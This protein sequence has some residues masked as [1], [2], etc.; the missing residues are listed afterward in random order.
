[1]FRLYW[2]P[3][4]RFTLYRASVPLI[5]ACGAVST[6][7]ST[8]D[9]DECTGQTVIVLHK[10]ARKAPIVIGV[11]SD[12]LPAYLRHGDRLWTVLDEIN[13]PCIPPKSKP[14]PGADHPVTIEDRDMDGSYAV[15]D[16]NSGD[17]MLFLRSTA[18][19]RLPLPLWLG[20]WFSGRL[21]PDD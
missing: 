1:L 21:R 11:S 14:K 9:D 7:A 20:T 13:E 3:P 12:A 16:G 2:E 4:V 6:A 8:S 5:A 15:Y 17:P 10:R 18:S 19:S